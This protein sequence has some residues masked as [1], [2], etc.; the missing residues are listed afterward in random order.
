MNELKIENISLKYG[1]KE[2]LNNL[3][4]N[5]VGGKMY[6]L[7]GVNGSGKTSLINAICGFVKYD[8]N[9]YVNNICCDKLNEYKKAKYISY[10]PQTTG[11]KDGF[12]VIDVVLMGC[13]AH[14]NIFSNT[15]IEEKQKATTILNDLGITNLEQDFKTLSEGEKELVLL[16]RSI[17]QNS[18]VML[19]DEVDSSL[20][21]NNRH[22]V[23]KQIKSII[24]DNNY[25]GLLSMHE[26]NFALKYCDEILILKDK[27]IKDII[28]PKT[29]S[30]LE[31][32]NKLSLIY[33]NIEIIEYQNQYMMVKIDE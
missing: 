33:E 27:S 8:G 11:L 18:P 29:D 3:S 9:I 32:K 23:L 25:I 21:F 19:M 15:S 2:V 26:P 24:K 14:Q 6:A 1:K 17:M 22:N 31:V 5:L 20:D 10:L 13:Y 12:N 16:A 30:I 4:I 7:L 28:Y